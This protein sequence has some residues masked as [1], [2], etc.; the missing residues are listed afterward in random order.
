MLCSRSASL[1]ENDARIL[2]DRQ[3]QLAVI[4]DLPLLR[5]VERQVADLRQAI[6]DLGDLLAELRL[7]VRQR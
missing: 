3:Q 6:D 7:D 5:R 4:L 1:I 2:R